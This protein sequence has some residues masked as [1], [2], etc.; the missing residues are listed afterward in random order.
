M[1][2]ERKREAVMPERFLIPLVW[3]VRAPQSKNRSGHEIPAILSAETDLI[4]ARNRDLEVV[5][6]DRRHNE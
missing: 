5:I 2:K 1:D 6:Y 4:D 3:I